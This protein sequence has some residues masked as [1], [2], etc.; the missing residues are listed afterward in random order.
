M[1]SKS[2]FRNRVQ[3]CNVNLRASLN[4]ARRLELIRGIA[5]GIAYLHGGSGD[6]V[7]HRDLKPGNILLDDEWKPKIADFGTAKLFAVDQTGPDQTI[8]VSP[9]YA[10][11]EY[12]RQGNM[13]LKCDV[14]SFGVILLE[15]LS[16]RRN[17]GMQGLLSHAWGL[18]ETNM[19]AELLDTTM[20]PL[21]ESEPELL[22]ELTRCIQIGLLCV[23]ETPCDRPTISIVVAMLMSTTSQIDRPRRMRPLDCEGFMP[24]DSSHG[25]ETE[26]L[27]STTIDLT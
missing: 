3:T 4:W 1:V 27:R 13:T 9:G 22:S 25:L 6:N 18:L 21:S 2:A 15:T 12:A 14:Y 17:G 16:G 19:I 10:A 26:L 23:Q 5:H 24:L 11:P 7:I 20:V 8:V